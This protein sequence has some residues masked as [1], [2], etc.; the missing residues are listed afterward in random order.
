MAD[1]NR[2]ALLATTLAAS[3]AAG[4]LPAMAQGQTTGLTPQPLPFDPA[5]IPGLSVT[6]EYLGQTI[7]VQDRS[8]GTALKS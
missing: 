1:L 6:F 5:A 3:A 4:A 8:S 7:E 2:R